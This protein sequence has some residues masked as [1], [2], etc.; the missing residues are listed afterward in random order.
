MVFA[1]SDKVDMIWSTIASTFFRLSFHVSLPTSSVLPPSPFSLTCH[2]ATAS[3]VTGPLASTSAFLAK[4]AT[5]PQ[6][7]T[8]NYSHLICIYVPDVYDKDG[9]TQVRNVTPENNMK[10]IDIE[11]FNFMNVGN[12]DT[13]KRA[14]C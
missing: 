9:I 2:H 12:E 5:S 11:F 8:P 7:E 6:S 14:W 3:L 13:G 1:P 4:V 10:D